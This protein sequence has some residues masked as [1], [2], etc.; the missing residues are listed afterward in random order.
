[1]Q[2]RYVGKSNKPLQRFNRHINE[3]V[4]N[5]KSSWI[6][7]LKL[8]GLLPILEIIDEVP[9]CDWEFWEK[10]YIKLYKS[11]GA[12][13]LNMNDGGQGATP[14]RETI[15]KQRRIK[16]GK[17]I[18]EE[19]RLKLSISNKGRK[20]SEKQKKQL[21]DARKGKPLHPNTIKGAIEKSSKKVSSYSLDGIKI[22]TYNS[23][24]DAYR[25]T[26]VFKHVI[27]KICKKVN[28]YNQSKGITFR[29][30]DLDVISECIKKRNIGKTATC[31]EQYDLNG[32]FIREYK[33][34]KEA[35]D[36]VCK[37]STSISSVCKGIRK[38][39]A[40]FIWKYKN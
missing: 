2:V 19:T 20:I 7:S 15:E 36:V 6:K 13:L 37:T 11:C 30:G 32:N 9:L 25:D 16:F 38:T 26:G 12:K 5:R 17:K 33:S 39:S 35:A 3:N 4:V 23:I 8:N 21:S 14:I 22:K 34:I 18:T 40:G 31:V 28:F 27:I 1:M 29:Y 24:S 10:H